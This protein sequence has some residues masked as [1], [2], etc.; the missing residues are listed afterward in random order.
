MTQI[1]LKILNKTA[2][3]LS[4]PTHH[5]TC[6]IPFGDIIC[7]ISVSS[8]H[9]SFGRHYKLTNEDYDKIS[10][11]VYHRAGEMGRPEGPAPLPVNKLAPLKTT[12][13]VLN[14]KVWSDPD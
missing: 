1:Q 4:W 7:L 8:M 9:G 5:Q 6:W 13:F 10:H 14:L 12:T 3:S 11:T 2:K